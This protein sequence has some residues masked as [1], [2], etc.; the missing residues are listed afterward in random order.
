MNEYSLKAPSLTSLERRLKR[1]KSARKQAETLLT[2]KSR[3]LYDA[4]TK[5][6]S[7]QEKLELALWASQESYWEWHADDDTFR[8]RSFGLHHVQARE[9]QQ[10][11]IDLMHRVHP[12]DLSQMQ[13]KWSMA[14]N[15][16]SD[17][18]EF[19]C[20]IRGLHGYQWTRARGRVLERD[21]VGVAKY[22]VGMAK[23]K[24]RE[25]KAEQSFQ[26]MASAF[27]SSRE[28]MLVL[29]THL[30]ITEA[31]QAFCE[32]SGLNS[33]KE[34]EKQHLERFLPQAAEPLKRI[35]Q[36]RQERFETELTT[37][38][39]KHIA[40][41]VSL[42]MFEDHHQ[43]SSYVIATLRDISERKQNEQQLRLLAIHDDLTGLKNR[44]GLRDELESLMAA[45]TPFSLAFIDLD[46]FKHINDIAGH[47]LGDECLQLVAS[48]LE[49]TF[50][51]PALVT[52]WG[53]DEFIITV[54]EAD[55][56]EFSR[57]CTAFIARLEQKI[58]RN[59]KTELSVSASIGIARYSEHGQSIEEI[60][61]NADAA[62]YR[63]KTSGKGK[64][65][66]YH[67]GLTEHVKEQ[68]SLLSDLRRA[69]RNR[70]LEFHVQGKYNVAGRLVGGELLC[71]WF[72]P[73]HGVV[74]PVVFIPLAEK[75]ELDTEIGLMALESAC[76]YISM[77]EAERIS[78]PLSVNISAN[79]LLSEFFPQQAADICAEHFVSPELIEIEITESIFIQDEKAAIGCLAA[80]KDQG[81]IIALDDF[82]SGFSSLS[83]L[84]KFDFDVIK[85]DRSLVKGI[86]KSERARSLLNG[87]FRM[88]DSLRFEVIIEGIDNEAYLPILENIG[89]HLYQGFLFEKPMPYEQF[90]LKHTK[91]WQIANKAL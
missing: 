64:V 12:D 51:A 44:I 81:F 79:Q 39:G 41:D 43:N 58:F 48:Q 74:S 91:G 62:M 89:I 52:R 9:I 13:L 67:E 31:N 30:I 53:G 16:E 77:L 47:E 36:S 55:N 84:R 49:Q 18:V 83:Y 34:S 8:I 17:D 7:I 33:R 40:V 65:Y 80:L 15:G 4:L 85:L 66:Q 86:D 21:S 46:G 10:N 23:D 14:V 26:L 2:D 72:S 3:E 68:V 60:I 38:S 63:A 56:D 88:L 90:I 87:I 42:A 37:L 61:Q 78:L 11:A 1:E 27:A 29:S 75:Y 45:N 69:I 73:L 32:L 25:H 50:L 57:Q 70:M 59:G 54:P 20:R 19:I 76:E 28:P 22:I 35:A 6:R 24:T 82:G 71:R 5:S